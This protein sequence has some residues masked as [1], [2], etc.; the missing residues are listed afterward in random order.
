MRRGENQGK[1]I[2][3]DTTTTRRKS[4]IIRWAKGLMRVYIFISFLV[5]SLV[6][7]DGVRR[8]KRKHL[9]SNVGVVLKIGD[10]FGNTGLRKLGVTKAGLLGDVAL[11][12]VAGN[13]AQENGA[14]VGTAGAKRNVGENIYGPFEAG[15]GTQQDSVI[16]GQMG[17]PSKTPCYSEGQYI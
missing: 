1:G 17:C 4:K 15:F 8:L 7:V 16:T 3:E 9:Q 5:F 12:V 10:G 11:T 6:G 14:S 2:I 13:A